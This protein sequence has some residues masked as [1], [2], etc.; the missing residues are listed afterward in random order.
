M[1]TEPEKET[2]GAEEVEVDEEEQR[3]ATQDFQ[4]ANSKA[5]SWSDIEADTM[6]DTSCKKFLD[7]FSICLSC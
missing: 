3:E 4:D 6:M 1:R 7:D 2:T 5:C